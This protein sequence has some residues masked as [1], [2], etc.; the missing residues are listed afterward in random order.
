MSE[1]PNPVRT[2]VAIHPPLEVLER[3][4]EFQQ[5][6][7][8]RL[9][10]GGIR[11]AHA[12]QVHLTLR[13]LG[14]VPATDLSEIEAAVRQGC[15]PFNPIHLQAVGTGCFPDVR[16]PRVL[17]VGLRGDLEP[18]HRLHS[19]IEEATARWGERE[20]REFHPHLTLGRIKQPDRR[21]ADAL[22]HRLGQSRDLV[23]G[24][25]KATSAAL[26]RSELSPSG[27]RYTRLAEV[28]FRGG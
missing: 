1:D 10:G 11:W 21:L 15:E 9:C 13:F 25:W 7:K 3:V 26:M 20:D 4:V 8:S 6:L 24:G 14:D 5:E 16:R 2:F 17:W 22:A 28:V 27:A 12:D 23:F 19:S 18:L